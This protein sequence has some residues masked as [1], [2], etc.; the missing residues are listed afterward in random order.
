MAIEPEPTPPPGIPGSATPMP[1]LRI[2]R[3][4][5]LEPAKP[6]PQVF[7]VENIASLTSD[8]TND[9]RVMELKLYFDPTVSN[10]SMGYNIKGLQ[11]VI[12]KSKGTKFL[13]KDANDNFYQWDCGD[14]L[15]LYW[16]TDART[17]KDALEAII[18]QPLS[19]KL[20]RVGN[21]LVGNRP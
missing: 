6:V 10:L 2:P 8:W 14:D 3:G 21:N 16:I 19:M 12:R 1:A 4:T 7:P 20:Q 9:E 17:L 11:P 15:G 18:Y 5:S 13:L